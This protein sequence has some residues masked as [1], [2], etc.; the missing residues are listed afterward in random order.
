MLGVLLDLLGG[1]HLPGGGLSAGIAD[2]GR[3]VADYENDAVAELL[4]LAQLAE[5]D[6][7]PEVDVGT[8]GVEAHFEAEGPAGVEEIFKLLLAD[9]LGDAAGQTG[10]CTFD[11]VISWDSRRGLC[12][13]PVRR[14]SSAQ[15]TPGRRRSACRS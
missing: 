9:N 4:E 1:E 3:P 11:L 6:G 5:A 8:A 14:C 12:G 15:S 7:V 2:L 13:L 10:V